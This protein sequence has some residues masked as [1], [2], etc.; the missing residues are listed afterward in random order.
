MT[1]M[2]YAQEV[3]MTGLLQS[4][5]DTDTNFV[6]MIDLQAAEHNETP[7]FIQAGGITSTYDRV[8]ASPKEAAYGNA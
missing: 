8:A 1:P 2:T 7:G 3:G 5:P 4:L 6:R